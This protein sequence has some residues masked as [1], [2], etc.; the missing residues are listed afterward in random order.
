MPNNMP[1]EIKKEEPK[2][3]LEEKLDKNLQWSQLIYKQ[4]KKIKRRLNLMVWG[5][6]VKWL[7]ILAPIILALIFLPPLFEKLWQ[8]Y[9]GLLGNVSQVGK[10]VS[11]PLDLKKIISQFSSQDMEEIGKLLN[12]GLR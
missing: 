6:V 10:N 7:I 8:Q 4:N 1:E 11:G 9:G 5:G 2:L 3:S 12:G